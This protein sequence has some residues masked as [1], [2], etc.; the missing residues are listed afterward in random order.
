VDADSPVLL[1]C[2]VDIDAKVRPMVSLGKPITE[3][4]LK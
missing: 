1:D 4:V 2:R 3:F